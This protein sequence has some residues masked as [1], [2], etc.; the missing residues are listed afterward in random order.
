MY[1]NNPHAWTPNNRKVYVS[2]VS[3]SD[4]SS[5]R[6]PFYHS[7]TIGD[8]GTPALRLYKARLYLDFLISGGGPVAY[9]LEYINSM[10]AR[11]DVVARAL[12]PADGNEGYFVAVAQLPLI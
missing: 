7:T 5:L 8:S 4:E 11:S 9:R 2:S 6:H 12:N 3:S 10:M 1:S